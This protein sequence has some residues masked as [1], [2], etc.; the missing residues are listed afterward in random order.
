ML[1]YEEVRQ[2]LKQNQYTWLVTGAVA[3]LRLV[4][5]EIEFISNLWLKLSILITVWNLPEI[6][7]T[8]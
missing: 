4:Q 8:L 2:Y 6:K 1:R 3:K 7:I 5:T